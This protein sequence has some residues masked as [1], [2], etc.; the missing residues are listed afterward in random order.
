MINQ[1]GKHGKTTDLYTC[2][3]GQKFTWDRGLEIHIGK[4]NKLSSMVDEKRET[5]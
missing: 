1:E 4:M 5:R 3:C 2:K